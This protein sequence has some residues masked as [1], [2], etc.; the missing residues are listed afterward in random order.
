MTGKVLRCLFQIAAARAF[1][2]QIDDRIHAIRRDAAFVRTHPHPAQYLGQRIVPEDNLL[3]LGG[4]IWYV[5]HCKPGDQRIRDLVLVVGRRDGIN[6]AGRNLAFHVVIR[7]SQ[8][9]Q[10]G[11]KRIGG[12]AVLSLM[13]CLIQLIYNKHDIGTAC[14]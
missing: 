11:Q 10:K 12:I 3:L 13:V 2:V 7:E 4:I 8:I 14:Q 5:Y 9:V 1:P 6:S